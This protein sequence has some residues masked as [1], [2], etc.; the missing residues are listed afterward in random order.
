MSAMR[1]HP[2]PRRQRGVALIVTLFILVIVTFIGLI[3]MRSGMQQVAMSTNSQ[4]AVVLFQNA[5]AGT[6]SV[7][8]TI[9]SDMTY[10]NG[11]KG[12][13]TLIKDNPGMAVVGCF[14]K[15]GLK[16]ADSVGT[17]RT[18]DLDQATEFVSGRG[19][20]VVQVAVQT[21][22]DSS[23]KAQSIRATGSDDAVLPGGNGALVAV[24]STS[25]MPNYGSATK[26]Q[27]ET[28]L[29]KP[30]EATGTDP[31]VTSCL[32]ASNASFQTVVQEFVYGYGGYK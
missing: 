5:D 11:P 26:S 6:T 7:E 14:T 28:C 24:Y 8:S 17:P 20:V 25:V 19:V 15:T 27:I 4:V 16:L 12:P 2:L 18:C 1:N 29:G 32:V 21:P 31:T 13:I 10:A 30:Q 9:N 3:A 23:G 22:V